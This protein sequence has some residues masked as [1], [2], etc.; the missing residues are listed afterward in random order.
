LKTAD[1]RLIYTLAQEDWTLVHMA[2]LPFAVPDISDN[3]EGWGPSSESIPP[4]LKVRSPAAALDPGC[5]QNAD[6]AKLVAGGA[7]SC[8]AACRA[9]ERR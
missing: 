3:A 9:H 1:R 8:A 6:G 4:H 7:G 5:M 2:G